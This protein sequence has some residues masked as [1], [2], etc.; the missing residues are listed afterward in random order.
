MSAQLTIITPSRGWRSLQL[1]ELLRHWELAYFLA[2]RDVS[3]RY[4]QTVLGVGWAVA[5]PLLTMILFTVVFGRLARLPSDGI[6]Y[7]VFSYAALLAWTYFSTALSAAAMSVVANSAVITKVYFPRLLLPI[8]SVLPPL[9]DLAVALPLFGVLL[10]VFGIPLTWKVLAIPLFVAWAMVAA[11]GLGVWLAALNARY[12]DVR[13]TVPFLIQLWLYV[14]P[15]VY[16]SS[17]VPERYRP[18]Y[19]LNPMAG[20]IDGFRWALCGTTF[21]LGLPMAVSLVSTV[22]LLVTGLYFFQRVE[23]SFADVV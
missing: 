9:I 21:E 2:R 20:V 3:L 22:L 8:A 10:L 17:L 1:G 14:S 13:H 4:K 15:V 11:L 12:R 23:R 19:G 16:S 7:P 5:Q 18:W 6:P